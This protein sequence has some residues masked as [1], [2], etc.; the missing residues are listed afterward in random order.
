MASEKVAEYKRQKDTVYLYIGRYSYQSQDAELINSEN[1]LFDDSVWHRVD[2]HSENLSL[3]P[4]QKW[5][6]N[7]LTIR[8]KDKKLLL[9][10]WYEI[11]GKPVVGKLLA[12]VR[13]SKMRLLGESKGSYLVVLATPVLLEVDDARAVL[14]KY[15]IDMLS[16]IRS[17][18]QENDSKI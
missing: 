15:M 17:A 12:K 1:R 4:N 14:R 16:G 8:S 7:S 2:D 11:D 5:E 13:E 6:V 3:A 18:L 10:Y 9:W